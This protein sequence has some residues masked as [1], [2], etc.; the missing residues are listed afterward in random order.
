V[1]VSLTVNGRTTAAA[2]GSTLFECAEAL[3]IRVPTSC[4]TNG[5]CKECVVE[6]AEGLPLLSPPTAAESHLKAPFRLSCQAALAADA[7]SGGHSGR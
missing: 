2:A 3:G 1:P 5:K 4:L 7:R 6:I